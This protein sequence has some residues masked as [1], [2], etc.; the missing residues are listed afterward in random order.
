MQTRLP[1]PLPDLFAA[2]RVLCVQ[3]H[4]DDNDIAAGGTLARLHD[5]GAELFYLTV[6]DDLMGLTD[7]TLNAEQATALL[8]R[9][10]HA[11]GEIMGVSE[12]VWLGFP[13]AGR[14]DHIDVRAGILAAIR[15][16]RPDFLFTCD[17]WMSYEAHRDHVR[18]GLA[19][20]E[21]AILYG[22][23]RIPSSDPQVDAAYQEHE[24][25]GVAF[26]FTDAPNLAV[27]ISASRER[28]NA[29]MRCYQAQFTPQGLDRLVMALDMKAQMVGESE[30]MAYAEPLRLM[31][32]MQ[33]HGGL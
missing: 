21:A 1:L 2:R 28:K 17:P 6:T 23:T 10:Q 4:Y 12:Q 9:D 15:R 7:E 19:A 24:L 5:A 22:A 13:D 20:A 14:F 8:R 26:Y 32:P 16:L 27:D 33:L 29:A 3:P 11:A 30:G 18:A 25:L 31:L